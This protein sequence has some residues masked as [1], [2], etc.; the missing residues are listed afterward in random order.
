MISIPAGKFNHLEISY[1]QAYGNGDYTTPIPLTFFGADYGPTT[2]MSTSYRVRNAQVTWNYLTWP[3]PPE[4]SKFRFRTLYGFNYTQVGATIDAPLDTNPTFS[5]GVGSSQ[6]FDPAFGA[7]GEYIPSK[8]VFIEVRAWGF[9]FP[10]HGDIGD[11]EGHVVADFGHVEIF[12]GYKMFH[13]KTNKES[14]QYFTGT[15][16]GPMLGLRWI[17]R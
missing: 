13:F 3:A 8:H 4:D 11:V 9:G 17:F 7:V 1:F 16:S 2:L 15:I 5:P 10:Q 6:L 14:A 12:A